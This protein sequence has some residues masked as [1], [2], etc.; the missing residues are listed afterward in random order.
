MKRFA[1]D[2][3]HRGA[4]ACGIGP[5]V[6]AC[7][8]LILNRGGTVATLSVSQVCI[9]IFSMAVL[10][11]VTGGLNALYQLERLPLMAAILI[12]GSVLY[13]SYL[14]T[15]LLNGWLESGVLPLVVFSGIFVVGYLV[16][17]A[18]IYAVIRR[19]TA[20]INKILKHRENRE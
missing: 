15:Y 3:L 4:I 17:W 9:G 2:F 8:Y 11:F 13:A 18:I 5:V 7:V 20:R 19:S 14:G 1:L 16:I 6:L 10:A 12:H